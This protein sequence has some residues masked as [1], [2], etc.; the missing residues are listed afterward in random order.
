VHVET[1]TVSNMT[2]FLYFPCDGNS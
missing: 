2:G 1:F